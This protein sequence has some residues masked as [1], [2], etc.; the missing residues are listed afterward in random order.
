MVGHCDSS[1]QFHLFGVCLCSSEDTRDYYFVFNTLQTLSKKIRNESFNPS[2]V[3]AD[4]A[5]QVTNAAYSAFR[6]F[7]RIMCWFH[8]KKAVEGKLVELRIEVSDREKILQDIAFIQISKTWNSFLPSVELFLFKWK[9]Y[10]NFVKYFKKEWVEKLPNWYE[11]SFL[12]G[13]VNN[14]ALESVNRYFKDEPAFKSRSP[15]NYFLPAVLRV[16]GEHSKERQPGRRKEYIQGISYSYEIFN[17]SLNWLHNVKIA[18][19]DT[20]F[21]FR[22]SNSSNLITAEEIIN[23]QKSAHDSFDEMVLAKSIGCCSFETC[24]C[25]EFVKKYCCIHVVGLN[26]LFEKMKLPDLLFERKIG[27]KR[28]RGR[29]KKRTSAL[30]QQKEEGS[31]ENLI[32]PDINYVIKEF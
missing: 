4:A 18:K 11:G 7:T 12:K 31:S 22:Y 25:S 27:K 17:E 15:M 28:S 16:I 20:F 14:C 1:R 26:L 9:H 6:S 2:F 30:N 5:P 21:Y 13:T 29:P 32:I 8:M 24:N 3:I 19:H 23:F 10:E